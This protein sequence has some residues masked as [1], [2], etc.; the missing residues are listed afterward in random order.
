MWIFWPNQVS[1]LSQTRFI[2][3][4]SKGYTR[5]NDFKTFQGFS[6][7]DF[8]LKTLKSASD[9]LLGH[10][11]D[12]EALL[13]SAE[14]P[15]TR[16]STSVVLIDWIRYF[17]AKQKHI[18]VCCSFGWAS[19]CTFRVTVGYFA[20]TLSYFGLRC[21]FFLTR[22]RDWFEPICFFLFD[23]KIS[24]SLNIHNHLYF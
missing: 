1:D 6:V 9:A 17:T 7:L 22:S 10:S 19:F 16:E 8:E 14:L 15:R 12:F 5:L 4:N 3:F 20:P 24:T 13:V 2:W 11:D 18:E 23:F 21:K